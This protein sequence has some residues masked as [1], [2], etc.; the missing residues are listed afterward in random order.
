MIDS[1]K[2]FF[3][4]GANAT[5]FL[6]AGS[7]FFVVSLK[8]LASCQHKPVEKVKVRKLGGGSYL[9]SNEVIDFIKIQ[10]N[11]K[12]TNNDFIIKR[13]HLLSHPAIISADLSQQQETITIS[14][15]ERNCVAL[16]EDKLTNTI[17]DV[18]AEAQ[19]I[20]LK[21]SRCQQVPLI[22]GNISSSGTS[23]SEENV[24][25]LLEQ[26]AIMNE[27]YPSLSTRFSEIRINSEASLTLFLA[28]SH[29][30]IDIPFS[31]DQLMIRRLYATVAYVTSQKTQDG[32]VDLRGPEAILYR[33]L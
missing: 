33:K 24:K 14:I 2:R 19:I 18:D 13:A 5:I 29:F 31:L 26:L 7:I 10:K 21:K 3:L 27:T 11:K 15:K 16:V 28:N 22:R 23:I 8:P 9:K 4:L 20:S 12:Y 1:R 25:L 17:Y 32:W 6:L 30:R